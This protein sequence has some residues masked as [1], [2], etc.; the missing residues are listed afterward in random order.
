MA[1]PTLY[2]LHAVLLNGDADVALLHVRTDG[3]NG[4]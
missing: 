4:E 3:P 1:T 2:D